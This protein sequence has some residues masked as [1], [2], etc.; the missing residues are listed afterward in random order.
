MAKASD[1]QRIALTRG[2]SLEDANT[3]L[4]AHPLSSLVSGD[5][6]N[7]ETTTP[8][9]ITG[10]GIN[11]LAIAL[12]AMEDSLPVGGKAKITLCTDRLLITD[13]LASLYAEMKFLGE[14]TSFPEA[15]IIDGVPVTSFIIR[16]GSPQW[17]LIIGVLPTVL[18]VGLIAFAITRL[19]QI[20]NFVIPVLLIA[21]IS[22]IVIA[23]LLARPAE[24]V[25]TAYI[26]KGG[27]KLLPAT[28]KY[29]PSTV[30]VSK[31]PPAVR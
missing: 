20:A 8:K 5:S 27:P 24:R 1:V 10:Y 25:A 11:D 31:K 30:P 7:Q 23:G 3:L 16:K 29:L 22:G 26:S 6:Y 9:E 12:Q 21:G 13:E 17:A 18:I 15:S 4:E 19:T 28:K 2:V 14:H